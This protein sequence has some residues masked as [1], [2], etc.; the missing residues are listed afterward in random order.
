MEHEKGT[1]GLAVTGDATKII[2]S[3]GKGKI[4]EVESH[5]LVKEWTHQGCWLEIAISPD[6]RLVA[7]GVRAVAICTIM[8]GR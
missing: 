7:I 4:K 5:K 8:E 1:R 2:S 6:D 3:D